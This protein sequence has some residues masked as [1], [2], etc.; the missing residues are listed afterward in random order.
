MNFF[1]HSLN[2]PIERDGDMYEKRAAKQSVDNCRKLTRGIRAPG[3][4]A[5]IA[6]TQE[7][8]RDIQVLGLEV[9]QRQVQVSNYININT[10]YIYIYIYTHVLEYCEYRPQYG[11]KAA[12]VKAWQPPGPRDY[13]KHARVL[14]A[15][16][17]RDSAPPKVVDSSHDALHISI[18]TI[19]IT[20]TM[21]SIRYQRPQEDGGRLAQI[22]RD[23]AQIKVVLQRRSDYVLG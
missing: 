2:L 18:Y 16:R 21:M 12:L 1:S 15:G 13:R 10:R 22:A 11:P 4:H 23:F 6:N 5:H 8:R 7:A 20:I 19:T 17:L 14:L 3:M 9:E